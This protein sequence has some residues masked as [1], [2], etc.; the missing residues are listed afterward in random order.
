MLSQHGVRQEEDQPDGGLGCHGFLET[1]GSATTLRIRS[2]SFH[3][4]RRRA[5]MEHGAVDSTPL[6]LNGEHLP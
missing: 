4:A 6:P 3:D 5:T 2:R 1:C